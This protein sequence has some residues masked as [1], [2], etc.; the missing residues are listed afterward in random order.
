MLEAK[1]AIHLLCIGHRRRHVYCEGMAVPVLM[2]DRLGRELSNGAVA[3]AHRHVHTHAPGAVQAPSR[4]RT[5]GERRAEDSR[6]RARSEDRDDRRRV[7]CQGQGGSR[8]DGA[9]GPD[10][11]SLVDVGGDVRSGC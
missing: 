5:G 1:I 6:R 2:N 10:T 11:F 3:R 7:R 8:S 4:A 9:A